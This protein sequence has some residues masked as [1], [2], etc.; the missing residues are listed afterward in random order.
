MIQSPTSTPSK[1]AH[2]LRKAGIIV[3]IILTLVVIAASA[4][5]LMNPNSTETS[6]TDQNASVAIGDKEVSPSIIK[7]KQGQTVTWS[8]ESATPHKLVA[9]STS[10]QQ[11]IEGFGSDESIAQDESYSFTFDAKGSFTYEDPGEP[12]KIKGTVIVE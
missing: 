3:F 7:I 6:D 10:Q 4:F 1:S 9:S 11:S 2:P 8:N 5:M 12:E